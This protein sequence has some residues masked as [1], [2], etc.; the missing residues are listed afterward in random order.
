MPPT[1]SKEQ[2]QDHLMKLDVYKFMWPNN[3]QPR[4]LKELVGVAAKTLPTIKVMTVRYSP[5]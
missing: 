4:V 5:E 3:M 2:I 1:V